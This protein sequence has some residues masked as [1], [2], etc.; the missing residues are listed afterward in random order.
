M[1]CAPE[2]AKIISQYGAEKHNRNCI[3]VL[4][5]LL[6]T[7]D[8][9]LF[10]AGASRILVRA[11]HATRLGR[12]KFPTRWTFFRDCVPSVNFARLIGLKTL[13]SSVVSMKTSAA[14]RPE[15]FLTICH[16]YSTLPL[17][18]SH[19]SLRLDCSP[20][21][22]VHP[23]TLFLPNSQ[24][25]GVVQLP[26][27]PA[28]RLRMFSNGLLAPSFLL[29]PSSNC[30]SVSVLELKTWDFLTLQHPK[31]TPSGRA[32]EFQSMVSSGTPKK[33]EN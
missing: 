14:R 32:L 17:N 16:T 12:T 29:N 8:S 33:S 19:C 15:A 30:F 11:L 26:F 25:D 6:C 18:F 3:S 1:Q 2:A 23:S 31:Y 10:P 21:L 22:M 20:N 24:E 5:E 7:L 9:R 13:C 27:R 4:V 28:L